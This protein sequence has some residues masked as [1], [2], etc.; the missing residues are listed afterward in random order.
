MIK[1]VSKREKQIQ[2]ILSGL[3]KVKK[4]NRKKQYSVEELQMIIYTNKAGKKV[5]KEL[6]VSKV[7]LDELTTSNFWLARLVLGK[8]IGDK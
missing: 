2:H 5:I 4:I 8:Y 7:T 3:H 6:K 1:H